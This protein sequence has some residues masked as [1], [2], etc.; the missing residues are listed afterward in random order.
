MTLNTFITKTAWIVLI[1]PAGVWLYS[2]TTF[3]DGVAPFAWGCYLL[4]CPLILYLLFF[5]TFFRRTRNA[6]KTTDLK[7]KIFRAVCA[8]FI[9]ITVL[10]GLAAGLKDF[11][12]QRRIDR[13]WRYDIFVNHWIGQRD[14]H[15]P[16]ASGDTEPGPFLPDTTGRCI[17]S[18]ITVDRFGFRREIPDPCPDVPPEKTFN[19]LCLGGSVIFG[20]T[21]EAGD[22]PAPDMLQT[23]LHPLSLSTP[24]RVYN[25]GYPGEH[26]G[27]IVQYIQ[28]AFS[29]IQPN[30]IVFYEAI[31]WLAPGQKGFL[32]DRNS[33]LMT[34]FRNR[35]VRVRAIQAAE[36]YEPDA[37]GAALEGFIT[38]CR[39][40]TPV[41]I[42][43]LVT[44]SLPFTEND[45][46]RELAYWDVMQNGQGCARAAAIVVRKHNRR[47]VEIAGKHGVPLIDTL[48]ALN[49]KSELFIDSCHLTQ[50]GNRFLTDT[51][52]EGIAHLLP[53]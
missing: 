5:L 23:T 2:V 30:V 53:R 8:A 16:P 35:Q 1:I 37:F 14:F 11:L 45:S 19:I 28:P 3:G 33:L 29:R 44:F 36:R 7:I 20:M 12:H 43:V 26:I 48:P 17:R 32:L 31:N 40:L 47:I 18:A 34:C 46:P 41:A 4:L 25:G 15:L 24:V 13:D 9:L 21:V 42:P 6:S 49:G 51:I 39:L 52:A 27:S 10:D 38:E 22:L 50:E